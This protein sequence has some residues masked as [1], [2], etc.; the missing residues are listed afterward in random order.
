MA[1][2]KEKESGL[3]LDEAFVSL[4]QK[5]D[6][7][8]D[9]EISL[10]EAFRVYEEGMALLKICEEKIDLVDKQVMMID[11]D[12]KITKPLPEMND[13]GRENRR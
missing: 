3:T 4:D 5:I 1:N 10:E 8:Q 7:L 2:E 11:D 6:R 13:V 9:Q 12:G